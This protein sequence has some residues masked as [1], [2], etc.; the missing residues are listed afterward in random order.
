MTRQANHKYNLVVS[1]ELRIFDNCIELPLFIAISFAHT[2]FEPKST[3]IVAYPTR[4]CAVI[5]TPYKSIPKTRTKYGY[6]INGAN[7]PNNCTK[8]TKNIL[9]RTNL[10]RCTYDL[11][12]EE[13]LVGIFLD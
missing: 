3:M 2:L 13:K 12:I 11:N 9:L 4:T 10:Y 5:I 8:P 6:V 7:S 1:T